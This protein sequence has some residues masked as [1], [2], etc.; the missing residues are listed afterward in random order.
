VNSTLNK[1]SGSRKTVISIAVLL[2]SWMIYSP[3]FDVLFVLFVLGTA[4]LFLQFVGVRRQVAWFVFVICSLSILFLAYQTPDMQLSPYLAIVSIN[5]IV[6]Y[7]FGN[8]LVRGRTPVLIQFVK[9]NDDG[10]ELPPEFVL[11]LK[12]QCRAWT[13]FGLTSAFLGIL[14]II[15]EPFRGWI[16]SF[17]YAFVVMQIC[18]FV[19]THKIAEYRFARRENWKETLSLI[20]DRKTWE[21]LEF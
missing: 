5:L 15:W 13:L 16:N 14:A 8:S 20:S 6:A 1:F 10:S 7:V 21:N 4:G 9:L 18:W 12:N 3:L 11:Y 17:L 19:V 2:I